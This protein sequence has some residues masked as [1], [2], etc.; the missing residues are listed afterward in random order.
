MT[1]VF[2]GGSRQIGRLNADMRSRLDRIIEKR[3]QVLESSRSSLV[4]SRDR[5]LVEIGG[6]RKVLGVPRPV[7]PVNDRAKLRLNRCGLTHRRYEGVEFL[8][9]C[10]VARE[11]GFA[12]SLDPLRH[13]DETPLQDFPLRR[14][15]PRMLYLG[16]R[17]S[18]EHWPLLQEQRNRGVLL[19]RQRAQ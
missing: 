16:G 11:E 9:G 12:V 18:A 5:L 13:R 7:S 8:E 10:G 14:L 19:R 1:K 2:I 4:Q 17:E 15:A 3:A 6:L